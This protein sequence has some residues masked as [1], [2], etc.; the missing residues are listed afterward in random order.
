MW[1]IRYD[2]RDVPE[3]VPENTFP[4]DNLVREKAFQSALRLLNG[5]DVSEVAIIQPDS[6]IF[7]YF[8]KNEFGQVSFTLN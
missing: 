5:T 1:Q 3:F 4:K 7:G 2:D 6:S 8:R